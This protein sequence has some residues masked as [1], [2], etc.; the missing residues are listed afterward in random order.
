MTNPDRIIM[1]S[2]RLRSDPNYLQKIPSAHN[3]Y[4]MAEWQNQTGI[5]TWVGAWMPGN[6][7]KGDSLHGDGA[8][9][10]CDF[11]DK[12]LG[13]R[14]NPICR[15]CGYQVLRCGYQPVAACHGTGSDNDFQVT[16]DL[17]RESPMPNCPLLPL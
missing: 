10:V 1:I 7:N 11:H 12:C 4:L 5:P 2:P 17:G 9:R 3:G 8:D 15:E 14:K 6:Y 16:G 13:I